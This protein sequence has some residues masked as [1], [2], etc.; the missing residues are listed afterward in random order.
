MS[1]RC[2]VR[3]LALAFLALPCTALPEGA[4]PP[5]AD[6]ILGEWRGTSTCIDRVVAPACNDEVI[7]YVFTRR[8]SPMEPIHLA[9]D[10]LVGSEFQ[11]MYEMDFAYEAT[12]SSWF[13]RF[14]TRAKAE[15]RYRLAQRQLE[16]QATDLASK[17]RVRQ[18]AATRFTP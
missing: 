9:A 3:F 11:P 4:A 6:A 5:P 18:V 8:E 2:R 17:A 15:W 12:T 14:E 16:G 13:H 7:R 1:E 10:K